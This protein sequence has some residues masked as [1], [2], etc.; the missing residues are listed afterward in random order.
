MIQKVSRIGLWV[1][2]IVILLLVA[3]QGWS[4][5]WS[6]FYLIWPGSNVGATFLHIVAWLAAYHRKLGFA[7]GGISILIIIFAFLSKTNI[8]VRI[9]TIL[10]L[11]VTVSAALGGYLY[12]HSSLQDR[13]SLG[14]MADSFIAVFAVYFLQLF[15]MNKTPRFP[16]SRAKAG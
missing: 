5:G 6:A 15:F 8:Y 14:Q 13:L 11:A 10:G 9:L 12:V 7:I 1:S 4:G 2:T 3:V 16:W